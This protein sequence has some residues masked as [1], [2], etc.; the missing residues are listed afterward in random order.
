MEQQSVQNT[1]INFSIGSRS[2]LTELY[3]GFVIGIPTIVVCTKQG[4]DIAYDLVL[5]LQ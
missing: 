2:I 5:L 4:A 1:N 3:E